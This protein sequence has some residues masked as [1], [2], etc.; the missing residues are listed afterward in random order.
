MLPC[1]VT[2]S[3]GILSSTA[4]VQQ[5]VDA[6]G[7]VEQRELRVQMQMDEFVHSDSGYTGHPSL[8]PTQ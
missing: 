7:A 3:A 1:S 8:T 5:F 4:L 6:A 2:A